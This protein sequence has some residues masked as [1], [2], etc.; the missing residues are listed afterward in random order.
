MRTYLATAWHVVMILGLL[1]GSAGAQSV[2]LP[3]PRLLTITP[4][5]GQAGTSVD[6]TISGDH[7]E[8]VD[9]FWFSHSGLTA[10]PRNDAQGQRN[11]N[12]WS[13]AIAADCPPGVYEGRVMTRLGMSSSRVFCVGTLAEVTRNTANTSLETA[14]TL[15]LNTV[16]NAAVS[17]QAVDYYAFNAVA[18]QR[19]VI[20][21]AATGIDSKLKP[22]LVVADAQGND[23]VA[24]R[25]GGAIDFSIPADGKYIVKVHDLTFSGGTEYFY[26]LAIQPAEHKQSIPRLP[27]T[28]TVSSFSWPPAGLDDAAWISEAES[29]DAAD[30]VM[31]IT[32]PC[33][34]EGSFFPAADVDIFEFA[35]AKGDVWWVEVA[36]ERLG[37]PT[38]PAIVVQHRGG[39][40]TEPV[41]TD[42]VE[43]AD[44][45]SPVKVSSNGYAYDG[46]PY[47]AGSPDIIGRV[48]IPQDGVYRLQL[49]D[50]F[51]GTR[52]DPNN[53]YRLI[54]RRAAPDFAIVGWALHMELRNGDRNALSK[55]VALRNGSTTAFEVVVVR[56]DGFNGEIQLALEN[57]PAGVTATGLKIPA[58]G[59]RGVMLITASEDAPRGWTSA[60]LIATADIDGQTVTRTGSV[61]SLAWPVP[62]SW[63]EI[64]SPR[65][66]ADFPVSAGGTEAA[67]LTI[68]AQEDKVWEV[69]AGEALTLPL[70][71]T[72]RSEFSGATFSVRTFGA[73]FES[74]PAFDLP[75]DTDTAQAVLDT[76]RLKTPPGDYT[77]AFY[78]GPVAKYRDFPQAVTFAEAAL[79]RAQD[80][81]ATAAA[82]VDELKRSVQTATPD[83]QASLQN[84]AQDAAAQH[85]S[86]QQAVAAAEKALKAAIARATP[87]DVV[88][89][90]VSQPIRIRVKPAQNATASTE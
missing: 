9:E 87:K 70:A 79:K 34:I 56:R 84:A 23:L 73:G 16:C 15:E 11:P 12:A 28:R 65:L 32:L 57:L 29:N 50:L 83:Q 59:T 47:H 45:P 37:R 81:S 40:E 17:R 38:D 19:V 71:L 68:A 51:G 88:D 4:M 80:Q 46:P 6:V 60:S 77:I 64:P 10:V 30:S 35:A 78:G 21:C 74:N 82:R 33:Q 49:S 58:G 27:S 22:V 66:L 26:R 61:A 1:T 25:R 69:T 63:G 85:Q 48:E 18:G 62:D 42:V 53:I 2:G 75:L 20:D 3:A 54:I 13:I 44:I 89:I 86:A 90:V 24:E 14:M 52:S 72:R 31:A 41:W 8:D 67:P 55:P 39:T 7:L 36:S 5:G 76:G 43:L